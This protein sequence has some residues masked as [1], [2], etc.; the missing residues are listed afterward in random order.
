MKTIRLSA[1]LLG[2]LMLLSACGTVPQEE[3]GGITEILLQDEAITVN[4]EQVIGEAA[5]EFT[6]KNDGNLF[7]ITQ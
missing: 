4:G 6:I 2:M 3:D 5:T 1:L 7:T